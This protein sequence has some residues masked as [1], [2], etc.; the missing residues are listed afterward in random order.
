MKQASCAPRGSRDYSK[1]Q[2]GR[3]DDQ[4]YDTLKY[5]CPACPKRNY[6]DEKREGEQDLILA[7]QPEFNA[8]VEED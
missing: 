8:L 5:G 4:V 7:A 1:K 3:E 6:T 2:E